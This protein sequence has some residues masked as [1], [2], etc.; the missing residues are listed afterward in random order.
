MNQEQN[1]L[2]PNN[3]NTQGN[4]EI[5]NNQILN[6]QSFN[7]CM[8][9]NQ[10]PINHQTQ[11]TV[12]FQQS[13]MQKTT[14]QS[15]NNSFESDNTNNQNLNSKPTK[16]MN[17]GLIIGI[18]ATIIV[19]IIGGIFIIKNRN[20]NEKMM[21]YNE[22][23]IVKFSKPKD[24]FLGSDDEFNESNYGYIKGF[25]KRQG[26]NYFTSIENASIMLSKFLTYDNKDEFINAQLNYDVN[27][28]L[29]DGIEKKKINKHEVY[30]YIDGDYLDMSDPLIGIEAFVFIDNQYYI[31]IEAGL[32]ESE[33][34]KVKDLENYVFEMVKSLKISKNDGKYI[35]EEEIPKESCYN[36]EKL[37]GL[38]YDTLDKYY[39]INTSTFNKKMFNGKINFFG[40]EVEGK[41]TTNKLKKL[42]VETTLCGF[43]CDI[44]K[45]YLANT[46]NSN[47]F[48]CDSSPKFS[49]D[50]T[51]DIINSNFNWG[52]AGNSMYLCDYT[53]GN[54][55]YSDNTLVT[56]GDGWNLSAR[57]I[58]PTQFNIDN[59]KDITIDLVLEKLGNPTYVSG[60]ED[61]CIS[62]LYS[63]TTYYYIY[64]DVAFLYSFYNWINLELASVYYYPIEE[65]D[66]TAYPTSDKS[67]LEILKETEQKYSKN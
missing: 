28:L 67:K 11:Q 17:L 65:L 14:Q 27:K 59:Y 63:Y 18:I 50:T 16:K 47:G 23:Y 20:N 10:Q 26:E 40:I 66:G 34:Y 43:T 37:T 57:N 45:D 4:N 53:G 51:S 6:N 62:N 19:T 39:N 25:V 29:T 8:N 32:K 24:W 21:I 46:A 58:Y 56:L 49:I 7:Q 31:N 33:N 3:F 30:Y 41:I 36:E 52:G 38:K 15:V 12:S 48:Y 13:I 54:D 35:I 55:V 64:D 22:K 60:R 61:Q 2:N 44:S 5:P 9:I 42:G 1:N